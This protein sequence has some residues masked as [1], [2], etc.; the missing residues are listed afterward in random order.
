MT[1]EFVLFKHILNYVVV[2]P[3]KDILRLVNA[4][5]E[6]GNNFK[7]LQYICQKYKILP[8]KNSIR[9]SLLRGHIHC[10]QWLLSIPKQ[11]RIKSHY[12]MS[13]LKNLDFI[14][15]H[16]STIHL[17]DIILTESSNM[18]AFLQTNNYKLIQPIT[19]TIPKGQYCL[20]KNN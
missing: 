16:Y 10:I 4:L 8:S 9:I 18:V 19:F 2:K 14:L 3:Q 5:V 12:S 11:I 17:D 13:D 15:P 6:H 7:M 20:I 1:L